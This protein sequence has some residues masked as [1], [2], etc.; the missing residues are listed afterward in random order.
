MPG[1][2]GSPYTALGQK[3]VDGNKPTNGP[4]I[5]DAFESNDP[6]YWGDPGGF[7]RLVTYELR[8]FQ[9]VHSSDRVMMFYLWE[10]RWRVIWTDGRK[11]PDDPDPRW[12][13]YSVGR[14]ADD[15]T[16]VVDTVGMDKR[17]WIT[18][19]G[20]P[21]TENLRVEERYHRVNQDTIEISMTVTDPAI[22]VRPWKP[23]NR[24]P[25]RRMADSTDTMEMMNPVSEFRDY[26]KQFLNQAQP[27]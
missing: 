5:V 2:D 23:W 10:K 20:D 27:K 26:E 15:Y 7:P 4:R 21:H 9:I 11:L 16:F 25:L 8:P 14:W 22:Y 19:T 1:D 18:N 24:L 3:L 6:L 12:Y 13:G 17:T